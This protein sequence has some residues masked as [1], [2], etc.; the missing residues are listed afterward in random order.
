MGP[1]ALGTAMHLERRLVGTPKPD[2]DHTLDSYGVWC[3]HP[4]AWEFRPSTVPN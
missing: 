2:G 4:L 3:G 1:T